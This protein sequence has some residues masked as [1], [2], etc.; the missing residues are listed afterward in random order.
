MDETQPTAPWVLSGESIIALIRCPEVL[1]PIPAGVRRVRGP[2]LVAAARYNASPVG[3]HLEL[4]VGEPA[5]VGARFGWCM[6]TMVVDSAAARAGARA[7]WGL[8]RELG[9]LSWDR[10]GDERELR[11]SER[12]IVVRGTPSAFRLPVL[13]P[14]RAMQRR[15]DGPV[16]VP[17]RLRG[18]ARL[19]RVELDVPADDVLA[20][21]AGAHRGLTIDG[22]RFVVHP[23]RHPFGLTSSLRAPLSV[24]EAALSSSIPPG[25]YSSVG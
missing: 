3:P 25:A 14:V 22:M 1:G 2:V 17:G 4:A 6:S 10:D 13:V 8:P 23:A 11:W 21:I 18:L 7:N 19:A 20:P 16:V 5:R 12:S 9:T 24:P 15:G